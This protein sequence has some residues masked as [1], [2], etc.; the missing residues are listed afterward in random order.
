MSGR[1]EGRRVM[2]TGATGYVGGRLLHR[3][4]QAGFAVT[5]LARHPDALAPKVGPETH[6][7]QGDLVTGAGLDEAMAG[8]ARAGRQL[9]LEA[10]HIDDGAVGIAQREDAGADRPVDHDA[11]TCA[12]AVAF[13]AELG[14]RCRAAAHLRRPAAAA[15]ILG[16]GGIGRNLQGQEKEAPE[17]YHRERLQP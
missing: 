11:D 9:E 6:I 2:L 8:A 4:E 10:S 3:L 17:H 15:A 16:R 12:L 13:E 7:V 14:R 5:C 1:G